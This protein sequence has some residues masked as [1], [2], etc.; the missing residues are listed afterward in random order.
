MRVSVRWIGTSSGRPQPAFIS[1][2]MAADERQNGVAGRP[3]QTGVHLHGY[4]GG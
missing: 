4:S 3:A 2:D 1:P